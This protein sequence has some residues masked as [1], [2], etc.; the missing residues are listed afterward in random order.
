VDN[1]I[2]KFH[3][4]IMD[5]NT[6]KTAASAMLMFLLP[7]LNHT[8]TAATVT[9]QYELWDTPSKSPTGVILGALEFNSPPA[10]A[11]AGWSI[12]VT[13]ESQVVSFTFD[14]EIIDI[15]G[16]DI[17]GVI[18]SDTGAQLDAG[19]LNIGQNP[20]KFL[21]TFGNTPG[22]DVIEIPGGAAAATYN[23]QWTAVVPLPA[24]VWLFG[25]GLVGLI[26]I[27]HRKRSA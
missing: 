22:V 2:N 24:A 17:T 10:S 27:A 1:P 20:P 14:S 9:Y 16:L 4:K 3:G 23:G 21:L 5:K 12:G 11:S 26:G 25:S 8:V 6:L 13:D 15:S 7:L 18:F 19:A